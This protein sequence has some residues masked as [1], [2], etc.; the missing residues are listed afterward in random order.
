M[1]KALLSGGGFVMDRVVPLE[2]CCLTARPIYE[3]V[4]INDVLHDCVYRGMDHYLT[5][6]GA[7]VPGEV[8]IFRFVGPPGTNICYRW[9]AVTHQDGRTIRATDDLSK[10]YGVLPPAM[11][12]QF[13]RA[14][15]QQYEGTLMTHEQFVSALNAIPPGDAKTEAMAEAIRMTQEEWLAEDYGVDQP[16]IVGE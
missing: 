2:E 13:A 5:A 12:Q 14:K 6:E 15:M 11:L 9:L 8:G 3:K 7:L 10:L 1:I 4:Y 16:T